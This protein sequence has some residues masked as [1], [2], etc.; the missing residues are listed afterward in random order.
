MDIRNNEEG[1]SSSLKPNSK[2]F[3]I[4]FVAMVITVVV[5]SQIGIIS[6]FISEYVSSPLGVSLFIGLTVFSILSSFFMINYVRRVNSLTEGKYAHF[7]VIYYLVFISQCL[8]SSILIFIVIQILTFQEYITTPLFILHIV[9]YGIWIGILGLLARA[10]IFWYR[11][12]NQNIMIM[13][14]ALAMIAYVVNGVFGLIT[15]IDILTQQDAIITSDH[16]AYFPE[17][18][19]FS[20]TDQFN[21]VNQ[22]SSMIAF[23]LTWIGSVRLLY[24]NL[25][26]IGRLKFW[27]MMII[28]LIYYNLSYPLFVLGY[29]NPLG[30][31]NAMLNILIFSFGGIIA[32]ILFGIS[33]LSIARTL[34]KNSIVRTQLMLTAYGFLLFYLTGSATASQ[35]AYPPYG[36]V[37]ISLIGLSCY[38]IYSGLYISAQI[39]SQDLRLL[40]SIKESVNEQANFLGGIGTAQRNKELQ[41]KVLTI[42]KNLEGEIEETSG[43]ETS[44][45]ENEVVDYVQYVINELHGNKK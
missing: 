13:I 40:R 33:F 30:N 32:G 42:A 9:S 20:M 37:S 36:L 26:R 6:D 7:K 12:F 17:F 5:D 25:K 35:A 21:A 8:I 11:N 28:S 34:R 19:N 38:L 22:L 10:F 44:L 43:V 2:L 3:L 45:N 41:S 16:V 4:F 39:V 18:S 1:I 31:E 29:F 14:F 23:L 27:T 15:Q 24:Q